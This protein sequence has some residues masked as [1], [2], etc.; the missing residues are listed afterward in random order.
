MDE[1][2]SK[3][4]DPRTQPP[5]RSRRGIVNQKASNTVAVSVAGR[6]KIVTAAA[7][8]TDCRPQQRPVN[9]ARICV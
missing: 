2:H 8:A 4:A 6:S 3:A 5:S 1:G 9:G 7:A